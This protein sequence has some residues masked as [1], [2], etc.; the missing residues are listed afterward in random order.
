MERYHNHIVLPASAE[1]TV[2]VHAAH[3]ISQKSGGNFMPWCRSKEV[4]SQ[5]GRTRA[6][7]IRVH[8]HPVPWHEW[9][10]SGGDGG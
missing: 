6:L 1:E 2:L 8:F 9:A 5:I 3:G 10:G 4:D 7:Q